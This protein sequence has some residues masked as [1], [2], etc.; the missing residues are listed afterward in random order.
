LKQL[1]KHSSLRDNRKGIC[2][3]HVLVDDG[4]W[5]NTLIDQAKS[6]L[7]G[8][9]NVLQLRTK[10]STDIDVLKWSKA[11]RNLT[12]LNNKLFFV[13]DRFDIALAS[14]ADGVHLGQEDISPTMIPIN[15]R[16][17][18]LIGRSTHNIEQVTKAKKD[19][20]DYIA[21]GPI[22]STT[23]KLSSFTERG[24]TYLKD[25]VAAASPIPVIAIGGINCDNVSTLS[26]GGAQGFAVISEIANSPNPVDTTKQLI[27]KFSSRV[28]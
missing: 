28:K 22:F 1:F 5:R 11:L 3:L 8:G 23:T 19:N 17:R 2:G 20:V 15:I 9:A 26:A 25:A 16:E 6:A 24:I 4:N 12:R 18:L 7:R 14:E 10:V 27:A 13:N 21:F